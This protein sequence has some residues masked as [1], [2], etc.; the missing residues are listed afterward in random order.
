MSARP[1]GNLSSY[2]IGILASV[3]L[4]VVATAYYPGGTTFSANSVGYDWTRNFISSLFA[5]NALNGAI[6]PGRHFGIPT[7]LI[8]CISLGYVFNVISTK[9]MSKR[10]RK[11]IQIAGIGSMV[12][13]FLVVTPMHD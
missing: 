12:Y 10:H 2:L 1:S 4:F 3:C 9:A 8:F 5:A 7:M 11:M 6:N 13:A